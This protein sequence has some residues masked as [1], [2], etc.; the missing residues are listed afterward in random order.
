MPLPD[1]LGRIIEELILKYNGVDDSPNGKVEGIIYHTA[2]KRFVL[3][4][5]M[6]KPVE[7][8]GVRMTTQQA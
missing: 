7:I 2:G 6:N 3:G 8:A 1:D 4:Y 5:D